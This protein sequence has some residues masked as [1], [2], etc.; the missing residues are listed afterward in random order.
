MEKLIFKYETISKWIERAD[1]KAQILIGIQIFI[2]GFV[3]Q[4]KFS[5][6]HCYFLSIALLLFVSLSCLTLYY[7]YRVIR[8]RLNNKIGKSLIYYRDISQNFELNPQVVKNEL[9]NEKEEDFISDISN[10]VISLSISCDNK[11]SDL[12]NAE[13]FMISSFILG[14]IIYLI[15][16]F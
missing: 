16:I 3:L 9:L 12:Q 6:Y 7:L 1:T 15:N 4:E 8:P 5:F 13:I 10:Q 11:Y 2:T 14:I